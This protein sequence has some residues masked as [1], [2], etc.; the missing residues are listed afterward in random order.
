MHRVLIAV[1]L[2]LA[3]PAVAQEGDTYDIDAPIRDQARAAADSALDSDLAYEITR[4]LT[5]EV[6]PR[7]GG[8]PAEA[9]A[10]EWAVE[11]MQALGFENVRIEP[12]EIDYWTR[13]DIEVD[14]VSP[15]PQPLIA[16]AL[17]GSVATEGEGVTGEIAYFESVTALRRAPEG[18][19]DG[20]IVFIDQEMTRTQDGSGYGAAV[21]MRY[22]GAIEA[23]KRGASAVLI[24]SVGTDSHRFPHAGGMAYEENIPKI[25]GAAL[26]SPDADQLRRL[27]EG[28][29]AI[30]VRLKMTPEDRG[31]SESGN[32]IGEIVG[33]ERPEEIVLLGA[34]LDSWDL[35]TGAVDDGAGVGI[36][37]AAAKHLMDL[38]GA[39]ERTIRVVLF[40]SEEVGL[41]GAKA[42]SEQHQNTLENHVIAAESDFGAGRIWRISPGIAEEKL[43]I[44]DAIAKELVVFGVG[45]GPN[46]GSGGPDR[47]YIR[48][49]GV[50]VVSLN[51]DGSDYFDLHH[52]PDDTFDKIDPD[53]MAQ[54][55][56][57]YASF[58]WI[59]ANIGETFRAEPAEESPATP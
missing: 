44:T 42:Y 20:K 59:A 8:S 14:V 6:G 45:P 39:P 9:R 26:S 18:G 58:A 34:H 19:L 33:S 51:Q 23:G 47:S 36:V 22:A 25:P 53:A 30:T 10:R 52:T 7:L 50:P 28:G 32:V 17:G 11:K 4:S 24:R 27:M 38:Y 43:P 46:N 56:A 15:Y 1:V 37:T 31:K 3:A 40:G 13:G 16:T 29:E 2:G 55:V 35:G 12:F 57:V 48:R 21:Q 5:T 54:N 49:D 41:F